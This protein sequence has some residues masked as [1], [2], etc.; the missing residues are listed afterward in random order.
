MIFI[1][2]LS[3]VP[4]WC[5]RCHT[6]LRFCVPG[7]ESSTGQLA[8]SPIRCPSS[9]SGLFINGYV[10]KF[11][12][13]RRVVSQ[14][15]HSVYIPEWWVLTLHKFMGQ[16]HLG[17]E[18]VTVHVL[19]FIL[20]SSFFLS[21]FFCTHFFSCIVIVRYLSLSFVSVF[22]ATLL[23]HV[24]SVFPFWDDFISW[25]H[26][27]HS[28]NNKMTIKLTEKEY[29]SDLDTYKSKVKS[30]DREVSNKNE[31]KRRWTKKKKKVMAEEG[32][33]E[34]WKGNQQAA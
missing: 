33:L 17:L 27:R 14:M 28:S 4:C 16:W 5:R 29:E 20:L 30:K 26:L 2:K 32:N 22:P 18:Q 12:G 9:F 24:Q 8:N 15:L 11:K 21:I 34:I 3:C 25:C 6:R 23:L 7:S 10:G 31:G 13:R 19:N 1:W